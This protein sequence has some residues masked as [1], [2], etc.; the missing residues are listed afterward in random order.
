MGLGYQNSP[1][2]SQ[3]MEWLDRGTVVEFISEWDGGLLE[4]MEDKV[5][6]QPRTKTYRTVCSD[7]DQTWSLSAL[8]ENSY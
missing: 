2:V 5:Q 1:S 8:K 7:Q 6:Q 4:P 3:G